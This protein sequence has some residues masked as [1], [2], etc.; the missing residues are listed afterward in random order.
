VRTVAW[1]RT[2]CLS[3]GGAACL[4]SCAITNTA[5]PPTYTQDELRAECERHGWR[6]YPDELVGGFCERR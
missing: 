5:I 4:V 1:L 6:W 2:V 3:A